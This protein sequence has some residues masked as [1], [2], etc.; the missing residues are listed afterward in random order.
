MDS[1]HRAQ[2]VDESRAPVN[3]A[4]K[5]LRRLATGDLSR[6]HEVS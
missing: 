5:A 1:I 2:D 6:S 3:T 4:V